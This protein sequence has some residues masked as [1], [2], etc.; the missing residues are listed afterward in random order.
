[1]RAKIAALTVR[2]A[3]IGLAT[4]VA[5]TVGQ[6]ALAAERQGD[7]LSRLRERA[8]SDRLL[9]LTKRLMG[10][11]T[12]ASQAAPPSILATQDTVVAD[13][14]TD[15]STAAEEASD[16]TEGLGTLTSLR[17]ELTDPHDR[18]V[19]SWFLALR[20]KE[21]QELVGVYRRRVDFTLGRCSSDAGVSGMGTSLISLFNELET[22]AEKLDMRSVRV[23]PPPQ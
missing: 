13:C 16:A 3:A 2:G 21:T 20:A 23:P 4:V 11:S 10:I 8:T 12:D 5:I 1:M 22:E 18:D 9:A 7:A 15:L 14:F 19:A 6:P 17:A